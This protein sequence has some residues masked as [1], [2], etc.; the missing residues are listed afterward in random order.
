M[1]PSTYNIGKEERERSE[2]VFEKL[3]R[4]KE[5]AENELIEKERKVNDLEQI[6]N[7]LELKLSEHKQ[8]FDAT[9]ARVKDLEIMLGDERD[10][11]QSLANLNAELNI[12]LENFPLTQQSGIEHDEVQQSKE[13]LNEKNHEIVNL[14]LQINDLKWSLGEHKQWFKDA[15]DRAN[16]FENTCKEKDY[17][18]DDLTNRLHEAERRIVE[19]STPQSTEN[20]NSLIDDLRN[21]INKKNSYIDE[22]EKAKNEAQWHLG[23][24]QHWLQD[25][26]NKID[27]LENEKLEG[28]RKVR[29]L[30]ERL[31]QVEPIAAAVDYNQTKAKMEDSQYLEDDG[32]KNDRFM[33]V[34]NKELGELKEVR[35]DAFQQLHEKIDD[36]ELY[37]NKKMN[38]PECGSDNVEYNSF[39][40]RIEEL[41]RELNEANQ[42]LKNCEQ[43]KNDTEWSL[44]EHRQ[45]LMDAKN[46]TDE[47]ENKL[48]KISGEN[49][50]L[51]EEI[52]ELN[53]RIRASVEAAEGLQKEINDKNEQLNSITK[54][55]NDA[56]WSV[57]EHRQWL[58]DA[59]NRI[60]EL[61]SAL[62]EKNHFIEEM[63]K[64][65]EEHCASE[66]LIALQAKLQ[67]AEKALDEAPK[68][69]KMK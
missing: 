14:N 15:N 68:Q 54:Q 64:Y 62:T 37:L 4:Q 50:K 47:F 2:D 18:I 28:W 27:I 44:G 49:N 53:S 67:I 56:E 6:I 34:L 45:W 52:E 17:I 25:A 40:W 65:N 42:N 41:L 7:D 10:K 13:E 66:E 21:E 1:H 55:I 38:E 51:R 59:N 29:E 3:K 19:I 35:I 36:L 24:H 58:K 48:E 5:K 11:A 22:L 43:Q 46:K 60:S 8:C 69:E 30:E 23:E 63:Q 57:G 61:E 26:N 20:L 9:Q 33:L 39:G 16:H 31:H 32:S 12:K